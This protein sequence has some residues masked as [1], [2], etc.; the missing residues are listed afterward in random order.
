M[1]T[2]FTDASVHEFIDRV[3]HPVRRRDAETLLELFSRVTGQQPRMWGPTIIGFGEYHYTYDSGREGDAPAAAFSPRKAAT[4]VYLVPGLTRDP[5]LLERLGPHT[6]GLTCLY[7]KDLTKV[8][9]DALTE[10]V[11]ESY[12]SVTEGPE[13]PD[14]GEVGS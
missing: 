9:L 11:R 2:E 6:T 12:T 1:A 14:A 10:L 8:D 3:E 4:T 13:Q 5:E 7:L